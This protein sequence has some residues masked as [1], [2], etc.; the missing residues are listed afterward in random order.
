MN[1][2]EM[3]REYR[4][5]TALLELRIKQLQ[6]A[7]KHARQP[8]VRYRLK[9]RINFLHTLVNESRKTAFMLEHYHDKGGE[10]HA[11]RHAV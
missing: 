10:A 8:E 5:N 1:M 11:G 4:A 3:A 7:Q 2:C 9:R 6:T